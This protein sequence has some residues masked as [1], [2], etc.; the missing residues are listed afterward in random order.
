MPRETTEGRRDF[1]G[2]AR[3]VDTR[4]GKGKALPRP[5]EARMGIGTGV[6]PPGGAHVSGRA[7]RELVRRDYHERRMEMKP[8]DCR[9]HYV[10]WICGFCPLLGR[11]RP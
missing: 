3:Q 2:T 11:C 5:R 6:G 9:G 1:Q 10:P 4:E 7:S 8:K